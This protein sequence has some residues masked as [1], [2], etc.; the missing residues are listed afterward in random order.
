MFDIWLLVVVSTYE[1]HVFLLSILIID[2]E[3]LDNTVLYCKGTFTVTAR[4]H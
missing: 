1:L 4:G 3:Q 2:A